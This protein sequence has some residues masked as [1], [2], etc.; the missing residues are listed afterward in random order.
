MECHIVL[1][2]INSM[3]SLLSR[4]NIPGVNQAEIDLQ[5][6]NYVVTHATK[7]NSVNPAITL[8]ISVY[9]GKPFVNLLNQNNKL[10]LIVQRVAQNKIWE[11]NRQASIYFASSW[12]VAYRGIF[13]M[14]AATT[15]SKTG[16][17][18]M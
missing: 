4:T 13:P 15:R 7:L 17:T 5:L 2:L 3:H 14:P 6:V 16:N 11:A 1:Q 10:N 8:Q 9:F 18:A 12:S